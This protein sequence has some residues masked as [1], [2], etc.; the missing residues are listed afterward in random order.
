MLYSKGEEQ[1]CIPTFHWEVIDIYL[2]EFVATKNYGMTGKMDAAA[3]FFCVQ[4]FGKLE[5]I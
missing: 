4:H 5:S 1:S 3:R 2:K